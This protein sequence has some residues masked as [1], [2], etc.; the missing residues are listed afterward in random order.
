MTATTWTWKGGT[1][2]STVAA[3]WVLTS[4]AG[5]ANG[6]P[7]PGDV[8]IVPGGVIQDGLAELLGQGSVA[9]DAGAT[10]SVT[11]PGDGISL[12]RIVGTS[13]TM[14]VSGAAA[15]LSVAGALTSGIVIGEAGTGALFVQ[16][17]G[18]VVGT[19]MVLGGGTIGPS[20]GIGTLALTGTGDVEVTSGLALWDGSTIS[21]DATS[22]I[23]LDSSGSFTAGAVAIEAANTLIGAGTISAAVVNN[24]MIIAANAPVALSTGGSLEITGPVSGTGVLSL[25]SGATLQLDGS[26]AATQTINFVRA[27][28]ETLIYGAQSGTIS[29]PIRNFGLGDKIVLPAGITVNSVAFQTSGTL[30]IEFQNAGGTSGVYDFTSVTLAPNTPQSLAGMGRSMIFAVLPRVFVPREMLDMV[31]SPN[32]P[33]LSAAWP[34]S[35]WRREARN[36]PLGKRASSPFGCCIRRPPDSDSRRENSRKSVG[37]A[38]R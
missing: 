22:G 28:P 16:N 6:F 36:L 14:T 33:P 8:A 20:G 13:G 4:G 21:V 35:S 7:Q 32:W 18:S 5:N 26:L 23:D 38:G 1:G 10:I 17:G 31:C 19:T 27:A 2:L 9:I 37:A 3:N 24:G 11:A 15:R 25:A 12:G 30:N 34:G 29:N